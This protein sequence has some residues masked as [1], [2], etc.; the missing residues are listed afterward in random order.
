LQRVINFRGRIEREYGLGRQRVDLLVLW[1]L[2]P[3]QDEKPDWTR[4]QGLVQKVAVALKVPHKS[5]EST[6]V[7][8]LE[9]TRSYMDTSGTK[10]G[11]LVTF[12]RDSKVPWEDKIFRRTATYQGADIKVWGM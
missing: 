4:C 1:P 3:A 5:L 11:H 2:E 9:Q 6:I 8:G 10:E 7:Q 12:N